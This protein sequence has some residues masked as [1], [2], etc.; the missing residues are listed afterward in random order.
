MVGVGG[1]VSRD[2]RSSTVYPRSGSY[3]QLRASVYEGLIGSNYDFGRITLDLR[4]YRSLAANHVLALRGLVMASPGSP[5][6][7]LMPELGGDVL[8][9]GYFSGRFRDRHLLAVE[10]E[11]RTTIWSRIGATIFG[12]LGQVADSFGNLTWSGF[13]PAVG[14][15]LRILLSPD[16]GLNI[17]A[18]FG[19]GFDV[20]STGFYLGIGEAF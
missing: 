17:R 16:E 3:H 9:R 6:F 18:D 5:P 7:D 12:G 1:M 15:G 10:G 4:T 20:R 8:L 11:Y 13:H 14:T 19:Y 2:T